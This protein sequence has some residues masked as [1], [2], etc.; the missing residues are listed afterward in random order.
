M[1]KLFL[2]QTPAQWLENWLNNYN[3]GKK[4]LYIYI[5]CVIVPLVITDVLIMTL[6]VRAQKKDLN[7]EYDSI[8]NAVEMEL[9]Y[10]IAD[11][12][13]RVNEIYANRDMYKFL[14]TTF[15]D[16]YDYY[17]QWYDFI[18]RSGFSSNYDHNIAGITMYADNPTLING[19]YF[20][21]ME[22]AMEY[23]WYEE[24]KES[25][26]A[27]SF[28]YI[29][30]QSPADA[31]KRRCVVA[32]KM[33]Y[34]KGCD[35]IVCVDLDY[36]RLAKKIVNLNYGQTIYICQ[37]NTILF[38]N[39]GR[40]PQEAEFQALDHGTR[41][42]AAR[43]F[44]IYG[45]EYRVLFIEN[46][47]TL[48]SILYK[49]R[50]I[51]LFLLAINL[52]LPLIFV[53]M[54]NRSFTR[55][56]L[57]LSELFQNSDEAELRKIAGNTG[58]DEIG[59]LMRKY[60]QMVDRITELIQIVYKDRIEKQNIDL[61]RQQAEL[62]ALHAQINPHFLFNVLESIRMNC[63][64]QK[65]EKTAVLIERLAVLERQ[66][67]S[68]KE[69]YVSVEREVNFIKAY[70]D[71]Q[72]HRFPNRLNYAMEIEEDCKNLWIP[73]LTLVTFVENACVHGVECKTTTSYI[74][75][76]VYR[77]DEDVVMEI[78]D[79]GCGM[80]E[81]QVKTLS[82]QMEEC[83]ISA[84]RQT[85]HVGMLN[86]CLRMKMFCKENVSFKVESEEG[87]GTFIV[88]RTKYTNLQNHN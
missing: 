53:Q 29:G 21:Q 45:N 32:R 75:V 73:K 70:L 57:A 8:C 19:G 2:I 84:I 65:E 60:N 55:R 7:H 85:S 77:E 13:R 88:I 23:N 68:W 69:D 87:V 11:A 50:Q 35:K 16:G 4:L 58:K 47:H 46:H 40:Y 25:G 9:D 67:V 22:R 41:F 78:E 48:W 72:K 80:K 17:V 52:A 74:Y 79:T 5:F 36:N 51:V 33:D 63:L 76:R 34:M 10:A 42:A 1:N 66:M 31:L 61:A 39:D 59:Q 6:L 64:L 38:T 49:N 28:Y 82:K 18:Q 62:L 44:S 83:D 37:E 86:A 54:L 26:L 27:V 43:S 20:Q 30:K 81:E 14:D 71:L 56:L 24:L 3:I 15:E 12:L